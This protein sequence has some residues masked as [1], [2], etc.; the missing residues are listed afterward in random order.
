MHAPV[1]LLASRSLKFGFGIL[2]LNPV[3]AYAQEATSRSI[4]TIEET[5][6][7]ETEASNAIENGKES[8][9]PSVTPMTWSGEAPAKLASSSNSAK[10]ASEPV[11]EIEVVRE[12]FPNGK[13]RV[14]KRVTLDAEGNYVNHGDYREFSD[15]G[16]LLVTGHYQHGQRI[17]VW[18]KFLNGTESPLFKTYPFNKMRPP[19]S[20]TVEFEAD[21]MHG[22]WVISDR[23]KHVAFQIELQQGQRNGTTTVFHP[24]GQVFQQSTYSNG[25]LEGVSIE[26]SQDGKVV[27]E[28]IYAAGRKQAVDTEHF[29]NKSVKSVTR[30]LTASLKLTQPDNW[31]NN[32]LASFAPVGEKELHGEFVTYYEN[33]QLATKGSYQKGQLHGPYESWFRTGELSASGAYDEGQQNGQWTWRHANGMKRAV[34][35]YDKG[36]PQGETRAWDDKGKSVTTK[37]AS[38]G[39]TELIR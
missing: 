31:A 9:S 4:L 3:F 17:G 6:Q 39:S 36:T 29:N 22:V 12:R 33:G 26:K 10:P 14:E 13:P 15:R 8:S 23:D 11:V 28:D 21:N 34:A 16:E 25:L 1:R 38:V 20:S 19:F 37:A 7:T 2:L 24:N 30:Y 27:R 32:T 35:S 5:P 18:A